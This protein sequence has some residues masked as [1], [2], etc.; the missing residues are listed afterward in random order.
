MLEGG[1]MR[2]VQGGYNTYGFTIGILMLESR[3][4]R[5]PGDTGNAS[6]F[7]YPVRLRPVK[8]TNYQRLIL[9]QDPALLQPFIDAA[10]DLQAEGVRAITTNCGFLALFQRQLAGALSVPIFTSSLMLVPMLASMLGPGKKVGIITADASALGEAHFR[11]VGWSADDY[12]IAVIGMQDETLFNAVVSDKRLAFDVDRMQAEM[13]S[14]AERLVA[15]HPDVGIILFECTN[16]PPY[17]HAVQ[18]AVG[19]PVYHI[20]SLI[21]L[22]HQSFHWQPFEGTM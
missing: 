19:L 14:V 10:L 11:G 21:D 2:Q 20:F 13:V 3:F 9:D 7:R 16:M 22:V 12:P 8:G 4:P 18:Q 15:D 5:I 6:S 17:A 1:I